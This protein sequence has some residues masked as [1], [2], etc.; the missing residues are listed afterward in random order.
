M[1][2]LST[3]LSACVNRWRDVLF[4]PTCIFCRKPL[5]HDAESSD[6][7]TC[8]A[9]AADI[10]IW[11]LNH[12]MQ[13]GHLLPAH[14]SPGP[15]GACLRQSPPQL[16]TE[17]LYLYREGPVRSAILDWKLRGVDAGMLWLLDAAAVRLQITFDRED[18]LLPVPMPL[19]RMRRAGRHHAADLCR[20]IC[21]RSGARFDWRVLRRVGVQQR[22]SALDGAAR[23]RNLCKAFTVNNDY[24][25]NMPAAGNA[26]TTRLWVVDDIMTTGA[27]MHFACRALR[28]AGLKAHAFSLARLKGRDE[29]G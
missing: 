16:S 14:L 3:K 24:L 1:G 20:A 22:Q 29:A 7:Q 21:A 19:S 26:S 12:C 5:D 6:A 17:N 13:C 25:S 18:L 8:E 2:E 28:R 11:P 9:C 4:P 27:T 10:H 15:C 23:R